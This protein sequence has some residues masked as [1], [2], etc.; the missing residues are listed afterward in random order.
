MSTTATSY[1]DGREWCPDVYDWELHAVE[2]E[3]QVEFHS[4]SHQVE[5]HPVRVD[6]PTR[7]LY[8][9]PLESIEEARQLFLEGR[10]NLNAFERY[11][12][13]LFETGREGVDLL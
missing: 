6:P 1:F 8:P 10:I 9:R 3:E 12:E 11:L 7:E 2:I 4:H 5:T 13:W